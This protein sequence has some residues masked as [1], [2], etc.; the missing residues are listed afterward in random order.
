MIRLFVI[1][2]FT[3]ALPVSAGT[4]VYQCTKNGTVEFS[5]LPCSKDAKAVVVNTIAADTSSADKP[6][7]D[8]DI[9]GY[10]RNQQADKEI[11]Q[12]RDK[13]QTYTRQMQEEIARLKD[14]SDAQVN[15]LTGAEKDQ[16][17]A[18]EMEAVS[19]RYQA[20][21][22]RE[23]MHIDRLL[24]QKEIFKDSAANAPDSIDSFIRLQQIDRD[25]R[26]HLDKIDT[27]HTRL[28]NELEA[29]QEEAAHTPD[30][31]V[32]ATYDNALSQRMSAVTA[33]Y[34][35]LIDVEQKG[36]AR[37]S[38]ERAELMQKAKENKDTN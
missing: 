2:V 32:D 20:L 1:T 3:A 27:Y 25:M 5:Q 23:Q 22:D 34:T 36:L 9:E 11:A 4:T 28:D 33:K 26:Q 30:N 17:I 18:K 15:N 31:L 8:S 7:S 14:Q 35:T 29:L 13:I 10:I 38:Q 19:K 6:Q 16:A 24:A 21:I 12:H 37:L